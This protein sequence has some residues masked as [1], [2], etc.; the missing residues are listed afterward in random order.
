MTGEQGPEPIFGGRTGV[1]VIPNG[2]GN[3]GGN[4]INNFEIDARGADAGVE[5]R[6]RVAVEE[7]TARGAQAGAAMVFKR[8]RAS[9]T[10]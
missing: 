5:R 7:A 6:I 4:I 1:S 3:R 2:A 8:L 10:L 9:S